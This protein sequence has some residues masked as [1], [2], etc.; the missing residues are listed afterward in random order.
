MIKVNRA[1]ET[2]IAGL[3]GQDDENEPEDY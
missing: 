2:P 1:N 3:D